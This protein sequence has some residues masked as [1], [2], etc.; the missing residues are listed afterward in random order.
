MGTNAGLYI[1]TNNKTKLYQPDNYN[2][3][4][5]SSRYISNLLFDKSGILWIGTQNGGINILDKNRSRFI[6]Y[7]TEIQ[8]N[9]C[10]NIR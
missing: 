5:I 6:T 9:N 7:Q 10:I 2:S 3:S 1:I 8:S 4:S